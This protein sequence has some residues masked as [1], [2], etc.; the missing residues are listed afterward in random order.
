MIPKTMAERPQ[1][2][3]WRYVER[4]GQPTKIP[5]QPNGQAAKSNDPATW[6]TFDAVNVG[7]RFVGFVFAP[8]GGLFGIDLDNCLVK[9]ELLPWA[10]EIVDHFPGAY[11]EVSPSG[12]GVKL[13]CA[14]DYEGRGRK[15]KFGEGRQAVELYGTGRYFAV[16]GEAIQAVEPTDCSEGLKWLLDKYWPASTAPKAAYTPPTFTGNVERRAAGYLA[17]IEP[18]RC[19]TSSCHDRTFYAAGILY[20]GFAMEVSEA[21]PLLVSWAES[22]EH[23]WTVADLERKINEVAKHGCDKPRGWA[24]AEKRE[25][26]D[27]SW[28]D[29][30]TSGRP[31]GGDGAS[32]THE[33]RSEPTETLI[34]VADDIAADTAND[35]GPFPQDIF[36]RL[37]GFIAAVWRFSVETARCPQPELSLAAAIALMAVVCG[38]KVRD[39]AGTRPGVYILGINISSSGKD[40]PRKVNKDILSAA[41]AEA[42][43]LFGPEGFASSAGLLRAVKDHPSILFQIDEIGRMVVTMRDGANPHLYKIGGELLKLYS[44]SN[45]TYKGEAHADKKHD[46]TIPYPCVTLYGTH[47]P[48]LFDAVTMEN[49]NEGLLGRFMLFEGRGFVDSRDDVVEVP[50]PTEIVEWVKRWEAFKPLATLPDTHGSPSIL[51]YTDDAQRRFRS[52]VKAIEEKRRRDN[53]GAAI[54]W[55]R[56]AEKT[57]K[58]ALLFA[59]SRKVDPA[60]DTMTITVEDV[61]LA[62]KVS[63]W[64]T[65][66]MIFNVAERVSDNR[67]EAL[68]KK[69]LRFF[70]S[71]PS[72]PTHHRAFTRA[73]R[74]VEGRVRDDILKT[75]IDGGLL[76]W[77]KVKTSGRPA[78]AYFRPP[79]GWRKPLPSTDG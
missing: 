42:E 37:S 39:R 63:N 44:S 13:F 27:T 54:L 41:G 61:D 76:E 15:H 50:P 68:S 71:D 1:W 51:S 34:E 12:N 59:A 35:P 66:K 38:R 8:G 36:N 19:G 72:K 26:K 7:G 23:Q 60:T 9:G 11:V 2:V 40:H 69:V 57:A 45:T 6:S 52:H 31:K 32:V 74:A 25:E 49:V 67:T 43:S 53:E 3:N 78:T 28:M 5:F 79:P 64:T 24:L 46:I 20:W 65:R 75:L 47:T 14:G 29:K 58:L 4:D 77:T 62:V 70:G 30:M 55:S 10:A 48:Q 22:G 18:T 21:L 33:S 16:T 17:T 73:F 56:T